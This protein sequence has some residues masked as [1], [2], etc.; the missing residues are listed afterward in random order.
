LNLIL[1]TKINFVHFQLF[2]CPLRN[3]TRGFQAENPKSSSNFIYKFQH[4]LSFDCWGPQYTFC[5]GTVCHGSELP[6]VFNVFTDGG[7]NDYT[8][9]SAEK[10][11]ASDVTNAW[12]NFLW[13][14]NPNNYA[15]VPATFPAYNKAD[16][17][18][19][20]LD[21]PGSEDLSNYRS[22]YCDLWDS[23]GYFW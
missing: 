18:I 2:Y 7:E 4:L 11:L 21:E 13:N 23:L 5:V 20:F 22:S 3:V 12:S 1:L 8:P 6:F 14:A 17:T 15:T 16:D 10:L 9:T 19:V